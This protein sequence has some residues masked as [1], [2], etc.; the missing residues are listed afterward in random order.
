MLI[1]INS[2]IYN[3]QIKKADLALEWEDKYGSLRKKNANG[4]SWRVYWE[5]YM[6]ENPLFDEEF[7]KQIV[8][9][10]NVRDEKYS[11]GIQIIKNSDGVDEEFIMNNGKLYKIKKV[12]S[13]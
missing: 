10:S 12:E 8:S 9:Q 13:E 1:D 2:R 5:A 11:D 6:N 4:Q 3:R 7:K